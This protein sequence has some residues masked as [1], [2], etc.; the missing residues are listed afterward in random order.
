[1]SGPATPAST[2]PPRL[3]QHVAV[4]GYVSMLTAMSSS[5]IH[6]L[7][8]VF[9]VQALGASMASIGLIEGIAEAANSFI[10][11]VSGAASDRLGRRKPLVLAGYALSAVVKT[12]FPL[13]G[14]ASTVLAARVLDRLWKGIRVAPRDAFLA[15]VMLLRCV[16]PVSVCAS[17]LRLQDSSSDRCWRSSSCGRAATIS[18]SCSGSR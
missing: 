12:L 17:P 9:L 18:V 16:A 8:P 11:L 10:K 6:G 14:T 1:M 3:P 2:A 4:L 5:M 7:L 13:A 15:D